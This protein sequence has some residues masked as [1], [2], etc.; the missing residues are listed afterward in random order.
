M[1]TALTPASTNSATALP[2]LP[3]KFANPLRQIKSVMAQPAVRR[4]APMALL[5]GLVAAAALAWMAL[6][7]PP[8]KTL[9][10]NLSDADKQAVTTALDRKS[11]RLNSSHLKL[12]RMPSSA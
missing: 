12:S 7:S 4:S 8:Q 11:T 2:P 3:E 10:E 5:I 9:F 6:S 1:S